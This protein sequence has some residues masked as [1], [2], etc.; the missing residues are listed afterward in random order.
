MA[1]IKM[2]WEVFRIDEPPKPCL[3]DFRSVGPDMDAEC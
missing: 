1:F 2:L 3:M